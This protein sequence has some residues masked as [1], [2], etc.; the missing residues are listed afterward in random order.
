MRK[1]AD[2]VDAP[3]APDMVDGKPVVFLKIYSPFRTYYN[4]KAFS[5]SAEN[6]TGMFD[7]LPQHHSFMSLLNA[8]EVVVQA[9]AGRKVIKIS[10]GLMYVRNNEVQ[11]FLDV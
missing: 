7:V 1:H 10:G 11:V 9:P 3:P 4:D 2:P 5:V 8:C 6:Q